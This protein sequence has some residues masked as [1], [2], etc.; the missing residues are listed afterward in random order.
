[1]KNVLI[2]F[3]SPISDKASNEKILAVLRRG[4]WNT[5]SSP[6]IVS[7]FKK[8]EKFPDFWIF[9]GSGGTE[10]SVIKFLDDVQPKTTPILVSH[11]LS[12]SLPAAMEIRRYLE[13]IGHPTR[14]IHDTLDNLVETL[15]QETIFSSVS[16][17]LQ[18]FRLGLIGNPSEWLVA[19]DIDKEAVKHTW[20]IEIIQIPITEVIEK[21][22]NDIGS[23]ISDHGQKIVQNAQKVNRS[24]QQLKDAQSLAS[25]LQE[26]QL[27]FNLDAFSIE[28]FSII[29]QTESTACFAL[30]YF[31]DVGLV[32]GCEGD[33]PSTFSMIL[34][35]LLVDQPS[36]M[37]NIASVNSEKNT[38][39]LSHC[40]VPVE[41]VDHYEIFSH[42]ESKK[43]IAIRGVFEVG[44][45]VTILKV[46]GKTLNKW[47]L[48]TGTILSNQT[49]DECC[50][51]Q[52]EI[53]LTE[54]VGYF[55][56]DS[57]ANHHI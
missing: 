33:L 3:F 24:S 57:Y 26:I 48:S 20:G 6:E 29:Q 4:G 46:A 51:T 38:A 35:K 36:F 1:M 47:F 45:T 41:M 5:V 25:A 15:N 14:I 55:L 50:R 28:C 18:N 13:E 8:N 39:I 10:N 17:K 31:N 21:F 32:A 53:L 11:N 52:V 2:P 16:E 12:N 27:E 22:P 30:S 34:I 49:Q 23:E 7:L 9:I 54:S 19:S 42:Y 37:A 43:G 56:R 44:K 40:T